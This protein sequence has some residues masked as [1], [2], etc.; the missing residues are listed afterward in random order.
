MT[1]EPTLHEKQINAYRRACHWLAVA[2]EQEEKGNEQ[3]A[4]KALD[5]AQWWLDRL[6]QLEEKG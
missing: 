6:N 3:A 2:N 1:S 5:K 4:Q